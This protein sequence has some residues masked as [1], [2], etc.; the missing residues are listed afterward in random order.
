MVGTNKQTVT[1]P[2]QVF[3]Q[4][5]PQLSQQQIQMIAAAQVAQTRAEQ[6]AI[7]AQNA[8]NEQIKR[9]QP[10]NTILSQARVAVVGINKKS[11]FR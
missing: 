9:Q 8:Q 2:I 6:V 7:A 3:R 5:N 10:Q 11:A 4:S 1:Q